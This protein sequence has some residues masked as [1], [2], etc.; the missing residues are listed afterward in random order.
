VNIFARAH[1]AFQANPMWLRYF[2]THSG[3]IKIGLKSTRI[4]ILGWRAS[5]ISLRII[6]CPKWFVKTATNKPPNKT[7]K[8]GCRRWRTLRMRMS[9]ALSDNVNPP[10]ERTCRQEVTVTRSNWCN[11]LLIDLPADSHEN[12]STHK[13]N[14]A[15]ASQ[16]TNESDFVL[17]E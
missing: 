2:C 9:C 11:K 6:L 15:K 14:Y 12:Q 4:R 17:C 13:Q 1:R 7:F 8:S 16:R 10:D 5:I 3:S